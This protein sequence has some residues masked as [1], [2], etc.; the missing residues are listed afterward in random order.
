[1]GKN[2]I[3]IIN[4]EY[5]L[6]KDKNRVVVTNRSAGP[7][8]NSFMGFV[9]PIYAILLSFFDGEKDLGQVTKAA[10]AL[11]RKDE[12]VISKII[13][14]LLEN[15]EGVHF[16]YDG[17]HLSFPERLLVRMKVGSGI[18]PPKY[19][20]KDF[21]I[22]RHEIDL[23][24]RRLYV[25]L[26]IL[27]MVNT[28]CITDCVYCYADRSKKTDCLIPLNRLKGLIREAKALNMRSFDLTGGELFLYAHWEEF[29]AELT[30]N[31]FKPYISTKYP[32]TPETIDKLK[33]MGIQR[34][35][36]SIDSV[37]KE[38]LAQILNVKE[39][40]RDRLMETLKHIDENGMEI[41]TNTQ[42]T[43]LNTTHLEELVT[44]LLTLKNIKRINLGPIGY[45]LYKDEA[46]YR[47]YKPAL[48]D[49][50]RI[51]SYIDG[52]KKQ[53]ADKV[54]I[55]FSGYARES[56]IIDKSPEDKKKAFESRAD[57]SGNFYAFLI[58]PDGKVTVC[59]E[60]YR[61][62]VFI[63]G[64]LTKQSIEE[65]WNSKK[66]LELYNISRDMI[67][68]ESPCKACDEFEPCHRIKGVCWKEVL[69]AYGY[70]NWD[71]P[72]PKCHLAPKPFRRYF[73]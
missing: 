7:T 70:E 51:E 67:R 61:H 41:Y 39:E 19:D 64:D 72:D 63:I 8:A 48:E 24:T 25:P 50:K 26:D 66:A 38:E 4:P 73:L 52:L 45:S 31:G 69:Y 16:H 22:P 44:F 60:L 11:L 65:V 49:I 3:Y 47:K 29:L 2:D 37:I 13:D 62:P 40:F 46:N 33:T 71:Y 27:F 21:F 6:R 34:I 14:P 42:L 35:Q 32:I 68:D 55:N 1:M 56:E 5:D 36:I 10:T 54:G 53:Y 57:C 23:E 59:E 20:H 9:H 18:V 15:K 43:S 58:L 17:H 28:H 12:A 30:A